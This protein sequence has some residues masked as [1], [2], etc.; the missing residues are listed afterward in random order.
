ME[1]V[2][3]P[4]IQPKYIQFADDVRLRIR[5][6]D[7]KPGDRLPS[8]SEACQQ[9]GMGISTVQRAHDILEKD[10]LIV[11]EQ[12]RGTFIS[13]PRRA[14][15]GCIG[16]FRHQIAQQTLRK[17]YWTHLLEGMQAAASR[18]GREVLLLN[19]RLDA[20]RWEKIDAVIASGNDLR[21]LRS[22]MPVM[23]PCVSV[24]SR[25]AD[26]A[27]VVADE[28]S[29]IHAAVHHLVSL[30]HRRIGYM[31]LTSSPEASLRLAAYEAA[32]REAG[33]EPQSSWMQELSGGNM[34]ATISFVE[35]GRH[36][37]G[38]WLEAGFR[39]TGCTAL[40]M[41]NDETAI[42]A[43][44]VLRAA[45]YRVPSDISVVGFDGTEVA[46]YCSPP[47]TTVVTPL[48]EMGE[49]AV[50]VLLAG[51]EQSTWDIETQ[52]WTLPTRLLIRE[53]TAAC[54]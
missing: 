53:T 21:Q 3:A 24:I 52:T 25:T 6:G 1:S 19:P 44:E 20:V 39:D 5:S 18:A 14:A 17:P 15:T 29:G 33:I 47:L 31:K 22:S 13:A 16:F 32:L 28:Y 8:L 7:L 45:G 27:S 40:L 48:H 41:Q 23:L 35:M 9:W 2:P 51:L 50:E 37:M 30:G 10:G 46:E 26:T 36:S 42:G 43:I 4:T 12:G 49:K 11:R 38:V 34:Q 54:S